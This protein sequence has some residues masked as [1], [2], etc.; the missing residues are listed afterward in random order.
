MAIAA[1]TPIELDVTD[2][3]HATELAFEAYS[4]ADRKGWLRSGWAPSCLPLG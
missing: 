4:F 1:T 3:F 2:R